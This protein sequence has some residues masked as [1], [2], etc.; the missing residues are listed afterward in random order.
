MVVRQGEA[1]NQGQGR[2]IITVTDCRRAG[3][4]AVGIKN[5]FEEKGL[6]FRKFLKEGITEEEFLKTND[7]YA[8]EIVAKKRAGLLD[9]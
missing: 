4:C 6:D 9:G 8:N 5:W 7:G 2:N 1:D 3:H